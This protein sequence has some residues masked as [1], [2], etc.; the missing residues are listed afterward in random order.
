MSAEQRGQYLDV[1]QRHAD[2][3]SALIED[4]LELSRIEG[5]KLPLDPVTVPMPDVA[6]SIL[7]DMKPRFDSRRIDFHLESSGTGLALADRRAVEQVLVNLLDNAA[8]YTDEGGRIDVRIRAQGDFIRTDVCDDGMGIPEVDQS[9]IFERFYRVD[10]ARSRDL[11]GTG[12]GLAIVKHLVQGMGGQVQ[13]QSEEGE[14]TTFSFLL[15][16]D[17]VPPQQLT[18]P[19]GGAAR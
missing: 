16:A 10:K 5:G 7:Q 18:L 9:R 17:G 19:K 6:R 4:L 1:I 15:P 13:V 3:L 11:G 2:R 8:K 14:G 12:L